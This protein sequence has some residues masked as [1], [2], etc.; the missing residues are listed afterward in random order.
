MDHGDLVDR[1]GREDRG[2]PWVHPA[3]S[4]GDAYPEVPGEVPDRRDPQSW[5]H[6]EVRGRAIREEAFLR[7]PGGRQGPCLGLRVRTRVGTES[8]PEGKADQT[9]LGD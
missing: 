3:A 6:P 2:D 1:A 4:P 5:G 9:S 7:G 8:R